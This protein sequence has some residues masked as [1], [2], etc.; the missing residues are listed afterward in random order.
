MEL[1]R[2]RKV[3]EMYNSAKKDKFI[4]KIFARLL[5]V[6]IILVAIQSVNGIVDGII[7]GRLLGSESMAAVGLFSPLMTFL[8]AIA[9]VII[10]GS[11]VVGANYAGKGEEDNTNNI[12]SITVCLIGI[13]GVFAAIIMTTLRGPIATLLRGNKELENY[14]LGVA[15]SYVFDVLCAVFADYLQ[16]RGDVKKTY[17]GFALLIITNVVFNI[18]FIKIFKLGIMGLG[19]ATTL[20]TVITALIMGLGFFDKKSKIHF[21]IYGL[22]WKEFF[23]ILKY[24]SSAATFNIVLAIKSMVVNYVVLYIAGDIALGAMAVENSILGVVGSISMG[25]GT[26]T[27]TVGSVFYGEEDIEATKSVFRTSMKIGLILSLVV[28]AIIVGASTPL[29]YLFYGNEEAARVILREILLMSTFFIPLNVMICIFTKMY[30]IQGKMIL[31][32]VLSF[33]ENGLVILVTLGM[34]FAF[35]MRGIWLALPISDLLL[36]VAI[37]AFVWISKKTVTMK[38]EDLLLIKKAGGRRVFLNITED[39]NLSEIYNDIKKCTGENDI[40]CSTLI[41]LINR[42]KGKVD[43]IN[44]SVFEHEG[45]NACLRVWDRAYQFDLEKCALPYE[46]QNLIGITEVR[47]KL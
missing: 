7:G 46:V 16:L 28:T 34:G 2:E 29:S 41:E 11:Q 20:S 30:H 39:T 47:F 21:T 25:I 14:M 13:I 18:L 6:Q 17:I 38:E 43:L 32:N 19:L 9:C 33:L 10:V 15:F 3:L 22:P 35:G 26:T 24:G 5:P 1:L 4:T 31:T 23:K 44:V 12:F 8:Y 27:L 36:C 40:F 37:L 45:T 42:E